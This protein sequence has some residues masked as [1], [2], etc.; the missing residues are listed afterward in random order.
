MFIL[1][2]GSSYSNY[3]GLKFHE[4]TVLKCTSS[5]ICTYSYIRY[6]AVCYSSF[7][8]H[9]LY[10]IS[11]I[12]YTNYHAIQKYVCTDYNESTMYRVSRDFK[13]KMTIILSTIWKASLVRV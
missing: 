8:L 12:H 13:L 6:T 7:L 4:S 11:Y 2:N 3:V 1:I 5:K 9:N 10:I